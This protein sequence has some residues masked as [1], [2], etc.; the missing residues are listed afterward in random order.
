MT[1]IKPIS[2]E[3]LE[4]LKNISGHLSMER[5]LMANTKL[6]NKY[7]PRH[8]KVMPCQRT[9]KSVASNLSAALFAMRICKLL[10]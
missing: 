9:L 2:D 8:R 3:T 10:A 5:Q 7:R 6:K 4:V 1:Q